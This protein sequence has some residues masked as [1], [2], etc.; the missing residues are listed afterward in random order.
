MAQVARRT[1][2]ARRP[3][4]G[5]VAVR[6]AAA[7][8]DTQA[9][10]TA[11]A[12]TDRDGALRAMPSCPAHHPAQG[13][14]TA[15]HVG[16][17][18]A[19]PSSAPPE[20]PLPGAC[21]AADAATLQTKEVEAPISVACPDLE[22]CLKFFHCGADIPSSSDVVLVHAKGNQTGRQHAERGGP[23]PGCA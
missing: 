19:W 17:G 14:H 20:A 23:R 8:S 6:T 1:S 9:Q 3:I 15:E 21:A 12:S 18:G 10:P 2:S 7:S 16:G 5:G 4:P 13:L 22:P 11:S